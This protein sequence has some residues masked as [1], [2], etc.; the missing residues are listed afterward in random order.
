[1]SEPD[2]ES[3]RDVNLK[4]QEEMPALLGH[5]GDRQYF[6]EQRGEG[7]PIIYAQTR[8]LTGC[9]PEYEVLGGVHGT[10]GP[11]TRLDRAAQP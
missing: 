1:M 9:D 10:S 2:T 11:F 6:L 8:D 3:I 4:L 7:V 5:A